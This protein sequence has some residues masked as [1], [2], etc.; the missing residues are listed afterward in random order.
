MRILLA[1]DGSFAADRARDLVAALPWRKGDRVQIVSVIP[2][3]AEVVGGPWSMAATP[4]EAGAEP[5]IVAIH[6]DAIRRAE[7]EIRSTRS[8]LMIE[9]TLLHGRAASMIVDEARKMPADLIVVGHR[10]AGR[11]ETMLLGSVSAEVVDQA[12][13]PVLVARDENL[14]PLILADDRSLHARSAEAMLM[15]WPLFA[16]LEITV[17]TVAESGAP[18][19][20]VEAECEAVAGR[21]SEAGLDA[22][23]ELRSGNPAREIIASATAHRAN[24]IVM[25][26]RG[27]TGLRRL[28]VGS[29]ARNVLLNAPCS[30]LV[31]RGGIGVT[32]PVHDTTRERELIS[33]FG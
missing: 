19:A 30:V 20:S 28:M 9:S 14:G 15:D 17:L 7:H 16:G 2:V 12:P 18:S 27:Q 5:G 26:T 10:G 22:R 4:A 23:F 8:D 21:L 1:I 24:L 32:A 25:G 31:V 6:R 29:V 3:H 11:W 33:P 13:C